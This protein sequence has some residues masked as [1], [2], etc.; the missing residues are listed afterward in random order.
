MSDLDDTAVHHRVQPL[1]VRLDGRLLL[2]QTVKLLIHCD[3]KGERQVTQDLTGKL[4][5]HL[6]ATTSTYL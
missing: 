2:Q 5:K 3:G 1:D 4:N 6:D